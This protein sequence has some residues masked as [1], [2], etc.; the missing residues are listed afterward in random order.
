MNLYKPPE[1]HTFAMGYH[2]IDLLNDR[3]FSPVAK[4]GT[5]SPML[6]LF[7]RS[8]AHSGIFPDILGF[9]ITLCGRRHIVPWPNILIRGTAIRLTGPILLPIKILGNR[10]LASVWKLTLPIPLIE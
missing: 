3:G 2:I 9:P 8:R 4:K 6:L 1:R 5:A 10:V 7:I